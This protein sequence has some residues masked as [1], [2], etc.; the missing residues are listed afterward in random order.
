MNGRSLTLDDRLRIEQLINRNI[1]NAYIARAIDRVPSVI[2]YEIRHAGG[3]EGYSAQRA[4]QIAMSR[5]KRDEPYIRQQ[6][7]L[8]DLKEKSRVIAATNIKEQ[9][10]QVL[11]QLLSITAN[12]GKLYD[13]IPGETT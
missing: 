4:H 9:V 7:V 5:L 8:K 12:L 10:R 6:K 11:D 13:N 2:W 3:R 1:C